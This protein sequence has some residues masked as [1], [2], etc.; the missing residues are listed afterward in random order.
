[1][2]V[3]FLPFEQ[4]IAELEA[5]I[6]EL[7]FAA[8]DSDLK[9]AD[10]IAMLEKK[11]QALTQDIFSKLSPQQTL[12]LARHPS[13]PHAIDLIKRLFK[14]FD[15]M[16]GDRHIGRGQGIIA[17]TAYFQDQ[18]VMVIA[19]EKGRDVD[20]K[21]KENFGMPKPESYRKALRLMQLAD[22]FSLPIITLIDTP[23][24]YPGIQAEKENQSE[25]IARNLIVMAELRV[26][27]ISIVIGEGGSG[28]ALAISV[29]DRLLMLKHSVYSVISPEGCASILW[30]S[31]EKAQ[32]AT[33]A[34]KITSKDL[35]DNQLIDAVIDEPIGGAHRDYDQSANLIEKTIC[36][37]LNELK[38]IPKE[39]LLKQRYDKLMMTQHLAESS[40]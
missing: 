8:Q 20:S 38:K 24:A 28:G 25:A 15:E 5:K 22:K 40:D 10:E 13:R 35:L 9:I 6:N 3:E 7:K 2:D 33:T 16:Q 32:D 1:M 11:S 4:P 27:I 29:A 12:Q 23:G 26:P 14:N 31:A 36:H 17:G 34:M 37:H 21:V 19:Q 39:L 30:K 18:A